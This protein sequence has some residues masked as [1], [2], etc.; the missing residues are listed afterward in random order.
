M[1]SLKSLPFCAMWFYLLHFK[2]SC[3]IT[4]IT[5]ETLLKLVKCV[6]LG[7]KKW[8]ENCKEN[9]LLLH[10]RTSCTITNNTLEA[11][12]LVKCVNLG[13]KKWTENCKENLFSFFRSVFFFNNTDMSYFLSAMTNCGAF[14]ICFFA[15]F[16]QEKKHS[17]TLAMS[18]LITIRKCK[19]LKK[20]QF[21]TLAR[22]AFVVLSQQCEIFVF[23]A[24]SQLSKRRHL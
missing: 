24:I 7:T 14:F 18:N 9:L 15:D 1:V 12:K 21:H 5:L 20:T 22:N 16:I 6:N 4:N 2:T 17:H 8:T 13:T 11:L 3:T 23:A 19:H 10:F